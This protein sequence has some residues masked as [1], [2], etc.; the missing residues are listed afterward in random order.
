MAEPTYKV[1]DRVITKVLA[2]R[3]GN[4]EWMKGTITGER[5]DEDTKGMC[6]G[7]DLDDGGGCRGDPTRMRHL[8][9]IEQLGDIVDDA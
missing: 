1:G 9:A 3:S 4:W 6:Y 7:V 5:Y 2:M 8:D